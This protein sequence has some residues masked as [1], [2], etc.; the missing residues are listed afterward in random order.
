MPCVTW[1]DLLSRSIVLCVN[2]CGCAT[3]VHRWHGRGDKGGSVCVYRICNTLKYVYVL[4]KELYAHMFK[5]VWDMCLSVSE[6]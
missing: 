3:C 5:E 1:C 4:Y 2:T 6:G